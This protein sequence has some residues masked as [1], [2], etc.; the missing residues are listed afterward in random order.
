MATL[1][2]VTTINGMELRNRLVR[3]A[4]WEGMCDSDGRP[5]DKLIQCY[6]E[7][8][9]GGVG[10]IITGYAFVRPEGRQLSGKMGIHIDDFAEDF[11]RLTRVVHAA[12]GKIAVQLVHAGGQTDTEHAGRRPLAPSSVKVEQFPEVPEELSTDEIEGVVKAFADASRRA[13]AYGFDAVQLHGA[14]G[15]LINQFL[16]P[17]TNLRTDEYGGDIEGRMRFLM[18]I[19]R[20]VRSAVGPD[21]PVLIKL[22]GSD[23]LRGGLETQD[24]AAVARALSEEGIDAIEVSAGT[25]ASGGESPVRMRIDDAK[26]EG[27]NMAPAR[28]IKEAVDCPV[29]VVGGFR[30][31]EVAEGAVSKEGMDYV[32]MSRPLIRE[33]GLPGRWAGGDRTKA[34]C[35]SCNK[36]FIP[37]LKEGGIYCVVAKAEREKAARGG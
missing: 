36:C 35:M 3:S 33:P 12:G 9:E 4:T 7:L 29:M 27:F 23:N 17:H 6:R 19:Y 2:E 11:L 18:E 5:T 21:F 34:R 26:K 14:H 16:S 30:S 20:A 25:S 13:K 37:G 31:Y 28:R 10:L 24:A 1:F 15:Y 8:A 22:S 32:S